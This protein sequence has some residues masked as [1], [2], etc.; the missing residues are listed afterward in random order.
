MPLAP[1]TL[2][3]YVRLF[4]P[5][6]EDISAVYLKP[7]DT[8]Y[9]FLFEQA[10]RMLARP[11]EFNAGLPR[12]FIITAQKYL[13]GDPKTVRHMGYPE[14]RHFMLSDLYDLVMLKKAQHARRA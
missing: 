3:D 4:E 5:Y 7:N 8:R 10:A 13:A 11:S 14:N 9:E 2:D 12:P 1:P 6:G